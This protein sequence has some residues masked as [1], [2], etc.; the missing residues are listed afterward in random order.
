MPQR[1]RMRLLIAGLAGSLVCVMLIGG[2]YVWHHTL[3][4]HDTALTEAAQNVPSEPQ[5]QPHEALSIQ[6]NALLPP[7]KKV[8]AERIGTKID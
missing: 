7:V 5:L 8:R 3:G 4:R 1:D 2:A 6:Q